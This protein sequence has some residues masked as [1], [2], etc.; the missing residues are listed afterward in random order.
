[1]IT[2]RHSIG[3]AT[4]RAAYDRA[5]CFSKISRLYFLIDCESHIRRMDL[6][7]FSLWQLSLFW[8]V[9]TEMREMTSVGIFSFQLNGDCIARVIAPVV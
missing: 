7:E 8:L 4:R 9:S 3:G 2:P 1:M 5:F 6:H